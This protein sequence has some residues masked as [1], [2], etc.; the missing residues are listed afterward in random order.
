MGHPTSVWPSSSSQKTPKFPLGTW[1]PEVMTSFPSLNWLLSGRDKYKPSSTSVWTAE[2]AESH[3]DHASED[4]TLQGK[5]HARKIPEIVGFYLSLRQ[6]T[7][8]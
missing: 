5:I 8:A 2:P 4:H 1:K 6:L 7:P 3:E